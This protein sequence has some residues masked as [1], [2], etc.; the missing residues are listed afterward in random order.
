[1]TGAR[2]A[3]ATKPK[4]KMRRVYGRG[5][6]IRTSGPLHPMQVRYQA[7]PHPEGRNHTLCEAYCHYTL[8]I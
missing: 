6:W 2:W 3:K 4:N 8:R 5:D 1:M 7:A